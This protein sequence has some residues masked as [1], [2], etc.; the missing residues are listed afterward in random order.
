MQQALEAVPRTPS[1][2]IYNLEASWNRVDEVESQGVGS[3]PEPESD[4]VGEI[5]IALSYCE[6]PIN[7]AAVTQGYPATI[8]EDAI[9]LA[10]SQPRRHELRCWYETGVDV[11]T[12]STDS[13]PPLLALRLLHQAIAHGADTVRA[14]LGRLPLLRRWE[15][16]L[17]L[18]EKFSEDMQRLVLIA[19]NWVEW[20][21]ALP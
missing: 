17:M 6:S 4:P 3:T 18:E 2:Y 13:T 15:T 21:K 1:E 5:V 19:P 7:F 8:V 11:A 10:D 16:V 14:V 20:C 12:D 9:A